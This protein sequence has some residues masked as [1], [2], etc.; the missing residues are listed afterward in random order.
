MKEKEVDNFFRFLKYVALI[1]NEIEKR[2]KER[3]GAVFHY[4]KNVHVY[5]DKNIDKED[6][7]KPYHMY[8][9][10]YEVGRR[11]TIEGRRPAFELDRQ[12]QKTGEVLYLTHDESVYHLQHSPYDFLW[13]SHEEQEE[14]GHKPRPDQ[15]VVQWVSRYTQML[16]VPNPWYVEPPVDWDS[17]LF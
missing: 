12:G 8:F 11:V 3:R 6:K 10:D 14:S 5:R 2:E 1:L 13:M 4:A 15:V 17:I 16:C 7:G 9:V